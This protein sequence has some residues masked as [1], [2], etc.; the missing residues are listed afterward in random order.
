MSSFDKP[1]G[2]SSPGNPQEIL[3]PGGPPETGEPRRDKSQRLFGTLPTW[4]V[5][6]FLA[7]A[8][9]APGGYLIHIP[10]YSVGPGPS[11]DV[12]NA[13]D[14]RDARTYPSKGQ[15]L[16]TTASVSVGRLNLWSALYAWIDPN[17]ALVPSTQIVQPGH[18]DREQD[19]EN[20]L[21]MDASKYVAEVVAFRALHLP[22]AKIS[23]AR[24]LSVVPDRP[25]SGK[26]RAQDLIVSI[27]GKRVVGVNNATDL[28][29][30]HKVGD[31]VRI[32]FER[33]GRFHSVAM[34][35]VRASSEDRRAVI[36]V[37]L[38]AAYRLPHE[39]DIDTQQIVGPSGGRIFALSIYDAFTPED[40]TR[41]HIIAG[42]G[43][44]G[45]DL[46]TGAGVV[47]DIGAIEEKVRTASVAGADVFIAPADQAA[48]ARKVAPKG[49]KIIGV[50][51]LAQA[52]RAL[53]ALT[54]I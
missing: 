43:A 25:A 27:D 28:L 29:G 38:T 10:Y 41:G 48:A 15:L 7:I 8:I 39:V 36:G 4:L 11:I 52:L 49:M 53:R 17:V 47:G 3:A 9:I 33:R 35:T 16:L 32:G 2:D 6:M 24:I 20:Q 46:A 44:I 26:L 51:T 23:G 5:V 30:A 40:L 22:I 13:I 42:T 18:T 54:P 1:T 45:I 31:T 34:K 37:E 12:L 21:E 50:K 14:V 19:V